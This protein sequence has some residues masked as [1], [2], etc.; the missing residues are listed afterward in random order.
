[1]WTRAEL[2]W[3]A[4]EHLKGYYWKAFAVTLLV[5]LLSN[6]ENARIT[7][8][9]TKQDLSPEL[10]MVILPAIGV[11]FLI[12]LL[13]DVLV[14]NVLSVGANR[15]FICARLGDVSMNHLLDGFRNGN[16]SNVVWTMF[17]MDIKILLWGLLFVIPGIVKSYEYRMVPYILAEDPS[18]SCSEAFRRSKIMMDGEKWD[19]FVLQLSFLGWLL[20]G[21]LACVI[22]TLFVIPYQEATMAELYDRLRTKVYRRPNFFN[23]GSNF[24][25]QPEDHIF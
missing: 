10:I 8:K 7:E 4:R 14:L 21:M 9:L 25:S 17:V 16:Y 1:M 22:G 3:D 12:G 11:M 24:Q 2:K 20:L 15:F 19:T 18:V 13:L 23:G 5:G 6:N